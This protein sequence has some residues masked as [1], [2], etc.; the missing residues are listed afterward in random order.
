VPARRKT[1][2]YVDDSQDDLFLFQKACPQVPVAFRLE[3]VDSGK[4]AIDYLQGT[5]QY[6]NRS[7][8]PLPNLVMLDLKMSV[9][10]GFA[11]LRWIREQPQLRPVTVCI[12]TSSFQY[13][14][15]RQAYADGAD[16]FLTKPA[17]FENLVTVATAINQF[18]ISSELKVLQELPEFRQ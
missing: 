11:V 6:S 14:D 5:G 17:A 12:F 2:L 15:I 7:K 10:D 3:L 1:V 16:C 9:P 13:E 4:A 18:L 8:F